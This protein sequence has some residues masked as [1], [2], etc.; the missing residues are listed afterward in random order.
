MPSDSKEPIKFVKLHVLG[1]ASFTEFLYLF[2][3][4]PVHYYKII[5]LLI[6][7]EFFQYQIVN[8]HWDRQTRIEQ[9]IINQEGISLG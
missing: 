7:G 2:L 5:L 9:G 3:V 4:P 8:T 6:L 1:L